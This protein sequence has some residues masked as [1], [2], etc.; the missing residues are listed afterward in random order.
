LYETAHHNRFLLFD[1]GVSYRQ[2][3]DF[4]KSVQVFEKLEALNQR[5]EDNWKY[6]RYYGEYTWSLLLAHRPEEVEHIADV[7]LQ[8]NPENE[9]L[10]R[11]KG[12][13][14][15][16][17]GDSAD[18]QQY[19]VDFMS[20]AKEQ[21]FSEAFTEFLLGNM[22][23]WGKDYG[24]AAEHYRKAY[25]LD[26]EDVI[27]LLWLIYSQLRGDI[28]IEECLRLSEQGLEQ[29]PENDG[30]RWGKALS[31]HKLGWHQEALAI[32]LPLKEQMPNNKELQR[33]IEEVEQSIALQ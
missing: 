31:L 7:G 5:W 20:L 26:K 4:N 15:L 10:V 14:A 16:L 6:E 29:Y 12:A 17:M 22:H 9:Q 2:I 3:E 11:R 19:R 32:L 18:V 27:N 24:Q 33:D 23:R 28:N 1:L 25:E 8:I 21:G 30:F 13:A